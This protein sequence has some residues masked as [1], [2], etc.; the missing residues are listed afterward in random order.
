MQPDMVHEKRKRGEPQLADL[1]GFDSALR[2]EGRP[3]STHALDGNGRLFCGKGM[4]EPI[5]LHRRGVP[6]CKICKRH[7]GGPK[8]RHQ[9]ND[10][11]DRSPVGQPRPVAPLCLSTERLGNG[12]IGPALTDRQIVYSDEANET[13]H[14]HQGLGYEC[15]RMPVCRD[16]ACKAIGRNS[17]LSWSC[18][19]CLWH[20]DKSKVIWMR[21]PTHRS[22]E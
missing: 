9:V 4:S 21:P 2:H 7:L 10:G 13:G 17:R 18:E 19:G 6:S 5:N 8:Y 15:M 20:K 12:H 3:G 16:L 14:R 11:P 22:E 1:Y